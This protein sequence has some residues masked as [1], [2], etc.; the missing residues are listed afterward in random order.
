MSLLKV[1]TATKSKSLANTIKGNVCASFINNAIFINSSVNYNVRTIKILGVKHSINLYYKNVKAPTMNVKNQTLEIILPNKYKKFSEEQ[2]LKV[3][4]Q[5]LYDK[6]AE[7]EIEKI[8][9]KVRIETGLAPEDYEIKGLKKT[10]ADWNVVNS[11]ITISPEIVAYDEKTIEYVIL[12]E[13]CH[14]KYKI[15]TKNFWKM[16]RTYMPN[17]EQYAVTLGNI[18]Y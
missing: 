2:I 11:F 3:L 6:I 9:E 12:H 18:A 1:K 15:R 17:Y 7:T 4:T 8:M 10:V 16:V 5:K 14:L 13:F